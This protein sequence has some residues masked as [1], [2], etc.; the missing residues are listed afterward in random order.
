MKI[1]NIAKIC[2]FAQGFAEGW[3]K[4]VRSNAMESASYIVACFMAEKTNDG[5]EWDVVHDLL[6]GDTLSIPEWE[7]ILEDILKK[8]K[9]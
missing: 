6:C 4:D 3:E 7:S 9:G 1:K 8:L 5:V 2:N